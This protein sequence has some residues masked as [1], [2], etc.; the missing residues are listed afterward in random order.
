MCA[1]AVLVVEECAAG[2][3]EIQRK[4]EKRRKRRRGRTKVENIISI[5]KILK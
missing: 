4:N 2:E 5:I 3:G 1:G